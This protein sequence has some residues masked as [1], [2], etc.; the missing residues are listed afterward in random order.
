MPASVAVLPA[1][2]VVP[3][4]TNWPTCNGVPSTSRS[5]ASTLPVTGA[6]STAM[7]L[8][9]IP[10]GASLTGVTFR[11][12]VLGAV[13]KAPALSCTLNAKLAYAAPF[14]SGAGAKTSLPAAMSAAGITVPASTAVPFSSSVPAPGRASMRTLARV[15]SA[16]ASAKPKSPVLTAYA[17]SSALVRA[18]STPVGV[19]FAPTLSV[20]LALALPPRPSETV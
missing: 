8:S 17:V 2:Y 15:W 14:A 18:A 20:M 4:M 1:V 3:A 9:P 13:S 11:V 12:S 5:F 6:S 7:T 10:T 16:S 19:E